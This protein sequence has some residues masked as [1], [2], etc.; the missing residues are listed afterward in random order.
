MD[1]NK[2]KHPTSMAGTILTKNDGIWDTLILS[3]HN[4]RVQKCISMTAR[5][6]IDN[7]AH[8]CKHNKILG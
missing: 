5:T 4:G 1:L 6:S 3:I 8:K 2:N 7:E